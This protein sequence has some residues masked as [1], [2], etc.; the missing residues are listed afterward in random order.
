MVNQ[1]SFPPVADLPAN[2]SLPDPLT[3]WDGA[4]VTTPEQWLGQRRPELKALFAHYMYGVMPPPPG[5][6]IDIRKFD[7]TVFGGKATLKEIEIRFANLPEDGPKINLALFIPNHV[8]GPGPQRP[9]PVFL[10]LNATGNYAVTTHPDVTFDSHAW[11]AADWKARTARGV[12]AEFWAVE[13]TIDRGYAFATFHESDIDPDQH[14]FDDG[15]HPYCD[16]GVPDTERWGT[17]AAWAWGL[18]RCVDYLVTDPAI[19]PKRICVTGH[20]RRGKAALL[21]GAFD[22][23]VALVAPHQSGTG[24]CALSRDNDQETVKSINDRFPHWFNDV[25]PLFND[26]VPRLP[27]DQH[28]L[29]ALVAP[30]A[31]IDTE[32]TQDAWASPMGAYQSLQAADAVYKFL[33]APGMV[34][35]GVLQGDEAINATTAGNLL[36]YRRDTEHTLNVDYWNAMMDFADQNL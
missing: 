15:I 22:E 16:L 25:F 34:G 12:H 3:M 17:L 4:P 9:A 27:F 29:V 26:E 33:G 36:Q 28:L 20:S 19:D 7:T 35:A 32:G 31:L 10:A 8:T 14:D 18:Q 1:N 11:V 23:R 30:R 2:A 6:S 24:G 5:I 13:N 21:A